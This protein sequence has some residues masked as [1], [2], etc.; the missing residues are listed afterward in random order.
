V[1]T[2]PL[3]KDLAGRDGR[4]SACSAILTPGENRL[5]L[6]HPLSRAE[7]RDLAASL[8]PTLVM[9]AAGMTPD[10]WQ[11]AFLR[12]NAPRRLLL[13]SRQLGKSLVVACLAA[14]T[15]LFIPGALVLILCP[16]LRQSGETFKKLMRFLRAFD[17]AV[18]LDAE[19]Q[20]SVTL[21]TGARCV[22]LPGSV[23]NLVGFS[24]PRLVILDEAAY[25]PAEPYYAVRPMLAA[26]EGACL[27]ALSTPNGKQGWFFDEWTSESGEWERTKAI[28]TECPR[29]KPSFLEEERRS[30]GPRAFSQY[31]L[32]EFLEAADD[33]RNARVFASASLQSALDRV[34]S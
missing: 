10:P 28:A 20:L 24:A 26:S 5:T 11:A 34:F 18:P 16:S 7:R 3:R 27:V 14:W 12:S 23:E 22:C 21:A 19:T 6:P 13:C 4:A 33:P 25:I 17:P 32:A 9:R 1:T 2:P 31:H 30:L 8:D 29:I 15:L